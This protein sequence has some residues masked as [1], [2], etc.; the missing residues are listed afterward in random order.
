MSVVLDAAY[1]PNSTLGYKSDVDKVVAA[2]PDAVVVLGFG[3]DGAKVVS[4]MIE[5]KVGPKDLP[6]YTAD[7]MQSS[8]FA[9]KVNAS[10]PSAVQ[11]I[12]GTAPAAAIQGVEH[13]FT[14]EYAKTGND[15]IFSAYYYDCT[16]VTALA[17]V[18][19]KSLEADKIAAAVPKVVSDGEVCQTFAA[20]KALIDEGK[21]ID[22]NG[23]SGTLDLDD[24]GHVL[25]GYY[26]V[27]NYDAAGKSVNLD[28]P[29][30]RIGKE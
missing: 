29:Q 23:A 21:D 24:R 27:W 30:I 11:G 5:S 2:D 3:D 17:A 16:I 4:Q 20:C 10:D 19:A 26:D 25:N 14:A 13:P 7:G 22:Y 6:V 28:V 12:K 15:T 9:A 8:G 1:D 18:Q